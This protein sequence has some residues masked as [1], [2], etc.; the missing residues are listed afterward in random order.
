VTTIWERTQDALEALVPAVPIAANQYM[1]ATAAALPDLYL[2]YQLVTA[3]PAQHADNVET[4]RSYTMQ[5]TAWSRTGLAEL[6]DVA[7]AMVAAGFSRGPVRE[8]P[9]QP[10]SRH[11]GLVMEFHFLNEE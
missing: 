11:Y 1:A 7:G 4:L 3:P 6:P 8:Q 5:V 9:Y 10:E 2:V